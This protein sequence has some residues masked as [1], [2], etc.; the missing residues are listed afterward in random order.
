MSFLMAKMDTM[1]QLPQWVRR[2][3]DPSHSSSQE[4]TD[5]WDY[6]LLPTDLQFFHRVESEFSEM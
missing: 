5:T 2:N 3:D 1:V 4:K 6:V